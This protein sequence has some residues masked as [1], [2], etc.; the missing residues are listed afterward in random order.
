MGLNQQD[1]ISR[2]LGC[3]RKPSGNDL[4][5]DLLNGFPKTVPTVLKMRN[6][7]IKHFGQ[8]TGSGDA[9]RIFA[10]CDK[11]LAAGMTPEEFKK[12]T[13][14]TPAPASKYGN[15]VEELEAEGE[16]YDELQRQGII[17]LP[18]VSREVKTLVNQMVAEGR[19]LT[20]NDIEIF[21]RMPRV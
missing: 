20:P 2:M 11:Y 12:A 10:A 19:T 18:H 14:P 6:F 5:D 4:L 17:Q 16:I 1:E 9:Q 8:P 13:A 15:V 3:V 7:C 21:Q